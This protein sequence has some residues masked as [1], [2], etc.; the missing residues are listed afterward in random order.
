MFLREVEH[1]SILESP[2]KLVKDLCSKYFV[3]SATHKF[4]PGV[5]TLYQQYKEVVQFD[6]KGLCQTT[7]PFLC[8]DSVS[9]ELWH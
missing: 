9:C 2:V 7:T 4:C 5:T 8:V 1:S 6:I 3:Y